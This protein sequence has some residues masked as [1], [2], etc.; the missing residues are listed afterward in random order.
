MR[1]Q[2]MFETWMRTGRWSEPQPDSVERKFNPWHDPDDGRF[3]FAGQGKYFGRGASAGAGAASTARTPR[4]PTDKS[5]QERAD[6]LRERARAEAAAAAERKRIIRE[7]R[8]HDAFRQHMKSEEGDENVVYLDTNGHETVGIGHKVTHADGLKVGDRITDAQKEAFF[9]ADAD[10][11][12][13]AARAQMREAGIADQGFLVPLA[14][15][16]FQL[17][18]GWKNEFKKTWAFIK[19]RQYAAAATEVQDS[20][21]FRVDSPDRVQA[22]QEE[23]MR[24]E[25]AEQAKRKSRRSQ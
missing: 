20:K 16:N 15:V 1:P 24:L 9:R 21:W 18:T 11:A 10:K 2:S 5:P 13:R 14:S 25:L 22:F 17:G 7:R 4:K 6:A 8:E 19:A 3:T 23:L 12:L